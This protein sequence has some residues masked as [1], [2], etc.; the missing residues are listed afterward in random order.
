[1]PLIL[2]LNGDH[3]SNASGSLQIT[4]AAADAGAALGLSVESILKKARSAA[5]LTHSY[6]NYRYEDL[7]FYIHKDTLYGVWKYAPDKQAARTPYAVSKPLR[8]PPPGIVYEGNTVTGT[9]PLCEGEGCAE[10]GDKGW[11]K[12]TRTEYAELQDLANLT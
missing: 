3:T 7:M 12:R 5:V 11:V 9:C 1:M 8:D 6:A 4:K 10:C 2:R